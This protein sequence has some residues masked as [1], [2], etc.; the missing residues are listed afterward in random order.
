[1]EIKARS[2]EPK[3]LRDFLE[4][5]RERLQREIANSRVTT[6]EERAGYSNH[7]AENASVVFE[8][9]RNA[10]LLRSEERMLEQV[11]DALKRFEDGT[12]GTCQHCKQS[13]DR[14]RLKAQPMASLC[15]RCQ[16]LSERR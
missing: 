4:K 8:Q 1:M 10:A 6:D 11:E 14:A 16:S 5:E 13:I 7:M 12:Y 2:K 9:T 3:D 15:L